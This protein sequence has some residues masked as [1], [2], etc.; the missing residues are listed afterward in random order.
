MWS[1]Q[2]CTKAGAP[3]GGQYGVTGGKVVGASYRKPAMIPSKPNYLVVKKFNASA[4]QLQT[5]LPT[6]YY[7][8]GLENTSY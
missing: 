8:S 3:C 4:V 6:T 5:D 2:T 7:I 1:R